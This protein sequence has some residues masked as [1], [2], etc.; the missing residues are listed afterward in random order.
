M[1]FVFD[2]TAEGRSIKSL[3]LVDDSTHEKVAI[4]PER[5]LGG[6]Q[7]VRILEQLASTRGLPKPIRTENGK[8]LC[9]RAM[10]TGTHTQSVQ[11]FK[12]DPGKPNQN[13]F[14]ESFDGRFRDECLKEHWFTSMQHA[15][16][17]V[18]S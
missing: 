6:N 7:L 1:F 3:T 11:W 16:L 12:V 5:A 8:E 18:E 17:V 9:R 13:A 4:V 10:L 15:R 14:I 2:R